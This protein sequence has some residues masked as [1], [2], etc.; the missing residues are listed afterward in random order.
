MPINPTSDPT[1]NRNIV[2]QRTRKFYLVNTGQPLLTLSNEC[3]DNVEEVKY[4]DRDCYSY[5][6]PWIARDGLKNIYNLMGFG[7]KNIDI[8]SLG[9]CYN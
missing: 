2:T 7:L 4:F 6:V 9:D 5:Q 1:A 3:N 8:S